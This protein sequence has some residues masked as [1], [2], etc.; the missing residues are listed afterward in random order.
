[1]LKLR[2]GFR[3]RVLLVPAHALVVGTQTIVQQ[4]MQ[5]LDG[6]F[7]SL[8]RAERAPGPS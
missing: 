6:F 4:F 1:V 8:A 2:L 3:P 7:L 5:P